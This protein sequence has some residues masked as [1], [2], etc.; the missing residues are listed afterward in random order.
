MTPESNKEPK[1]THTASTMEPTEV[2][3]ETPDA[4]TVTSSNT[5]RN[6]NSIAVPLS[7]VVAGLLIAGSVLFTNER[8]TAAL[9]AQQ[10]IGAQNQQPQGAAAPQAAAVDVKNITIAGEPFVGNPD[11]PVTIAYWFDYQ[12]PF[13]Q[14]H[15]QQVMPLIMK[16]Y[17]DTGKAKIVFK[18]YAFL[19]EDSI[20]A[21]LAA[22]AVWEVAPDKFYAWHKMIFDNQGSENG[23][24]AKKANILKLSKTIVGLDVAKVEAFMI[25]KQKEY[26]D[27][28]QADQSEGSLYGVT[29]TPAFITGK[30]LVMG[31]QP[32][33][34]IKAAIDAALA[35]K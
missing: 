12:C 15:E 28:M 18:D 27:G 9:V 23:G 30:H 25:S 1:A 31:A 3:N 8:Q 14:R 5:A 16:E 4:S 21:A 17:V 34:Q 22:R 20:T 10:K 24:W 7:I 33:A 19:G 32:Y 11:A 2:K 29:G 13:C 26:K 6:A 35:E